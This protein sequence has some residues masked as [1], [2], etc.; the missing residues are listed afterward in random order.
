MRFDVTL[1]THHGMPQG[2]QDDQLLAE[3]L[4]RSGQTVRFAV[5]NEPSVDWSASRI[6]LVRSTWDYHLMPAAWLA[7]IESTGRQ[8][9]LINPPALLRWNTDKRYL[10][11]LAARNVPC[12]PTVLVEG[13]DSP[14]LAVMAANEGWGDVV[15]KPAI[16][17]S[18]RGARRF[19]GDEI[20]Q[21]GAQHLR[22][23]LQ[24]GG[25]LVQPFMA[26]VEQADERC[27]VFINGQFS[28]AFTK[29]AFS[30]GAVGLNLHRASVEELAVAAQALAATPM[31]SAYARVDLIPGEQGPT[32]MELELI[33]PDMALRLA[34]DAVGLL[35]EAACT[36][37]AE[38]S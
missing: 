27:L 3:A 11:E 12:L 10:A 14:S 28:H 32:L 30:K 22:L 13:A 31:A 35:A 38:S 24:E 26:V 4:Q 7:W 6:T 25:V 18:A 17:A 8:T 33:E 5:W 37:A 1:V 2:A 21:D 34:P 23:L 15:V 36:Y 20:A 9:C 19:R 29:P 16:G